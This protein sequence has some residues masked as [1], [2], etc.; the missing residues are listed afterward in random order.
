M[1]P[2]DF[3]VLTLAASA[4]VHVWFRG[5]IF[6]D[7]RAYSEVRTESPVS[8]E[9]VDGDDQLP[10]A[11]I[12]EEPPPLWMSLADR[13]V[14]DFVFDLLTCPFCL[15]HH[16]PYVIALLCF[17]PAT[18][19]PLFTD[20]LSPATVDV[21]VFLLKAPAYVLAATRLGNVINAA[22]PPSAKY[23]DEE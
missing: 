23:T 22:I 15:S 8:E 1:T 14:P 6:S 20:Y 12:T 9:F 13:V 17:L 21:I 19:V 18:C 16:T 2:L 3:I 11:L 10:D 5:S 4:L 7:L